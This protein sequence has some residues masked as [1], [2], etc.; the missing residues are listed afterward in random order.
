MIFDRGLPHLLE[1]QRC[2]ETSLLE[3]IDLIG[4]NP[5]FPIDILQE[6]PFYQVVDIKLEADF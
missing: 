4:T 5:P 2:Q 1:L 6:C 3:K